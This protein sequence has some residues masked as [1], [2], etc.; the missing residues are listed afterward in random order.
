MPRICTASPLIHGLS[1]ESAGLAV[2]QWYGHAADPASPVA[3][4]PACGL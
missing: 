2:Y 3:L 4:T 1:Y